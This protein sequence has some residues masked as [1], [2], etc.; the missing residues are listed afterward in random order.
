MLLSEYEKVALE[1]IAQWEQE[2]HRGFHKGL[3]DVASKP[4][5]FIVKKVGKRRFHAFEKSV[6]A[7]LERLLHASIQTIEASE[8]IERARSHGIFINSLSELESCDLKLLDT[9]IRKNIRFHGKAAAVQGAVA[10]LGGVF[11]AA[12]DIT[13]LLV[14]DFHMIHEIAYCYGFEPNHV[15]EKQILLRIIE[16]AIG[17]SAMKF[18]ALGEIEV[19]KQLERESDE[20]VIEPKGV[21]ILG[22]K[23]LEELVEHVAAALLIRLIPRALPVV[24]SVV[25]AHSN[26]EIMEHSAETAFMVYRKRFVERKAAMPS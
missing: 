5:D 4:V 13:A 1:E 25:S 17:G 23:A 9:C 6:R 18:K 19:L 3:L 14:Q 7:T 15:L 11:I 8:L 24:S 26:L 21:P 20:D 2:K 10:G 12:A 16:A 22:A